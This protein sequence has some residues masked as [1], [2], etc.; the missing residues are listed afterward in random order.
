MIAYKECLLI[1]SFPILSGCMQ[2]TAATESVTAGD[3]MRRCQEP[4]PQICTREYDP[5][6]AVRED[7]SRESYATGCTACAD[8]RVTAYIPGVCRD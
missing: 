5:V 7:G 6:C 1:L 4:R 2:T 3:Q 8:S